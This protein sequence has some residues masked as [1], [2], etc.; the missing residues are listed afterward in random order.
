M[1]PVPRGAPDPLA[2][3]DETASPVT[4]NGQRV[5]LSALA[6]TDA[7]DG[8]LILSPSS[9]NKPTLRLIGDGISM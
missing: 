9:E 1:Y 7:Y 6:G 5:V 4:Y 8:R 3:N 2:N